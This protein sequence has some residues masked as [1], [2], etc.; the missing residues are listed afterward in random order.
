MH[1]SIFLFRQQDLSINVS[2]PS[3]VVDIELLQQCITAIKEEWHQWSFGYD[4][5]EEVAHIEY[6]GT[7]ITGDRDCIIPCFAKKPQGCNAATATRQYKFSEIL[8]VKLIIKNSFYELVSMHQE[9]AFQASDRGVNKVCRDSSHNNL[10]SHGATGQRSLITAGSQ[11]CGVVSSGNGWGFNLVMCIPE[12]PQDSTSS[13]T[14]G[15]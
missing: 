14:C 11:V 8:D 7:I 1:L 4:L 12:S 5:P 13:G 10:L 2:V 3:N 6:K 9:H 15:E